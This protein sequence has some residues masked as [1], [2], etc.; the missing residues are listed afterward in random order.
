MTKKLFFIAIL[1]PAV[2][3][4]TG[5]DPDDPDPPEPVEI[6]TTLN[7]TL[8][9]V[10]LGT[11]ITL[12]FLDLDGDGG[13]A[14]VITGGILDANTTYSG[15]IELLNELES[16]ADDITAEVS[17][18]DEEHQFF[19]S[20]TTS[21]VT[22]DYADLDENGNPLGLSNTLTTGEAGSGSITIILR[23]EPD[24]F[25][26][27]VSAGDITNAGGETDIEVTFSVAVQ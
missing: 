16:P 25:A 26:T 12:S 21:S 15:S 11:P 22:I 24:K 20:S 7:F 27:D 1:I 17:D 9:P 18:E 10:T 13:D 8:T 4:F 14:P 5:C 6:I 2:L 3:F 19:F 23:H